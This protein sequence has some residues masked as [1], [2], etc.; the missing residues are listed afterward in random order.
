MRI[1]SVKVPLYAGLS[2]FILS[3]LTS[4]IIIGEQVFVT[5][6]LV[7][8]EEE[9]ERVALVYT[10]PNL[11]C[12]VFSSNSEVSSIGLTLGFDPD[13]FSIDPDTFYPG[14]EFSVEDSLTDSD[15]GIA[16]FF[17]TP[18]TSGVRNAVIASFAVQPVNYKGRF[19]S[20]VRVLEGD[21]DMSFVISKKTGENILTEIKE[22]DLSF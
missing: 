16:R 19:T 17:L 3:V 12:A 11:V 1:S 15:Y 18:K 13:K 14:P 22:V 8:A 2:I 21:N 9:S 6:K 5:R 7:E 4:T 10:P 20:T